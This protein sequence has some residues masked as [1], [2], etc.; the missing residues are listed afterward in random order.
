MTLKTRRGSVNSTN[1][2]LLSICHA[3]ILLVAP[4]SLNYLP[5]GL[6]IAQLHLN[7]HT[8]AFLFVNQP[9]RSTQKFR[10]H[11][12]LLIQS[13][14][15]L[16]RNFEAS[17]R[18]SPF[19]ISSLNQLKKHFHRPFVRNAKLERKYESRRSAEQV[20]PEAI[21]DDM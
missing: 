14:Y 11:E 13:R 3:C 15:P 9:L 4:M 19:V 20:I 8:R 5:K 18:G 10:Y 16:S 2:G 7:L 21:P 12:N 1:S 17:I 6:D